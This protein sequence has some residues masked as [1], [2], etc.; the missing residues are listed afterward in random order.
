MA[1]TIIIVSRKAGFR[2]AGIE[3]PPR[4]EYPGDHF[5]AEQ[6]EQLKAEP[7]LEVIITGE[8]EP[9]PEKKGKGADKTGTV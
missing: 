6:L 3:H 1:Q 9:E 8:P 2:R 5:S 7:M 4:A